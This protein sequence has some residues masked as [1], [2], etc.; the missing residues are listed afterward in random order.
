MVGVDDVLTDDF[1]F[2]CIRTT[3]TSTAITTTT[4]AAMV[5]ITLN[6]IQLNRF[7]LSIR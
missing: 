5:Q 7:K 4:T 6:G 3:T 2:S 1:H